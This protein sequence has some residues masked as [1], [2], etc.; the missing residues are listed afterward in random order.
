M[1]FFYKKEVELNEKN[2][3]TID[4]LKDNNV[5]GQRFNAGE[6]YLMSGLELLPTEVDLTKWEVFKKIKA[7]SD[8][9]NET[10]EKK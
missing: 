7:I 9:I 2:N 8:R 5:N 1:E 10:K 3:F 6:E 4:I